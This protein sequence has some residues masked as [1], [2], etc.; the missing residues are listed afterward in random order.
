M[1]LRR[2]AEGGRVRR[3]KRR[4]NPSGCFLVWT[5]GYEAVCGDKVRAPI[6]SVY[7]GFY[8]VELSVKSVLKQSVCSKLRIKWLK[9]G[10]YTVK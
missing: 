10:E 1:N 9:W 7:P 4:R 8:T 5:S 6:P 2:R 3:V